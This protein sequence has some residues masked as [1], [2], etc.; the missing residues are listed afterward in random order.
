[1]DLAALYDPRVLQEQQATGNTR[2]YAIGHQSISRLWH[3]IY[4]DCP[5]LTA[6]ANANSTDILNSFLIWAISKSGQLDWRIHLEFAS[7]IINRANYTQQLQDPDIPAIISELLQKSTKRWC[8][9][10]SNHFEYCL[11][12]YKGHDSYWCLS[13]RSKNLFDKPKIF[14]VDITVKSKSLKGVFYTELKNPEDF[15]ESDL[16]KI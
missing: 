13:R 5:S 16:I 11:A 4:D 14:E 12:G 3:Q 15:V 9:T 10:N 1:M 2:A 7:W 8:F 6:S